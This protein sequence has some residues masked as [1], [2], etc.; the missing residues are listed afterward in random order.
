MIQ[1]TGRVSLFG[2]R[3]K[4]SGAFPFLRMPLSEV[5]ER[6]PNL[7]CILNGR[8]AN[9]EEGI[10]L[11]SSFRERIA[12]AESVLSNLADE[13]SLSDKQ[14]GEYR[15]FMAVERIAQ[16]DGCVSIDELV[17]EVGLSGR[18]LGRQFLNTVGVGPKLLARI[19]RFQKVFK[20]LQDQSPS[21]SSIAYEC[22]YYDQA[23]LIRDFNEFA[24]QSPNSYLA[25]QHDISDCFTKI[26]PRSDFSN[27][28]G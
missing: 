15:A 17:R 19:F 22:G 11:A 28:H 1:P 4:P 21:W 6:I 23:H 14:S 26:D 2:I 24:G 18:H 9:L 25:Q 10:N 8:V 12:I 7:D 20:A 16:A 13:R 27:T 5:T 3:F